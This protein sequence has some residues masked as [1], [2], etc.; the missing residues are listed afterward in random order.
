MPACTWEFS[1][2]LTEW[3]LPGSCQC[4]SSNTTQP[5]MP[6]H[7]RWVRC[8]FLRCCGAWQLSPQLP[9]CWPTG[10]PISHSDG[11]FRPQTGSLLAPRLPLLISLSPA[12]HC[13]RDN[14]AGPK[15]PVPSSVPA[16]PAA[17]PT[18]PALWGSAVISGHRDAP[19]RCH[20]MPFSLS[21]QG[22][23]LAGRSDKVG[24]QWRSAQGPALERTPAPSSACS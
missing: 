17:L 18:A 6:A 4:F 24:F 11:S 22:I 8:G 19:A 2:V 21:S 13:L 7:D 23:P 3:R 1:I 14:P 9:L 12:L 16:V 5:A 10:P 15:V 20:Q